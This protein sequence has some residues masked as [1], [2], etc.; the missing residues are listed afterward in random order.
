M[1]KRQQIMKTN[2][3]KRFAH[4]VVTFGLADWQS[5]IVASYKIGDTHINSEASGILRTSLRRS[6]LRVIKKV[7]GVDPREY[8]QSDY[9]PVND[10]HRRMSQIIADK[11][12]ERLATSTR[13]INT[14]ASKWVERATTLAIS[15]QM[16]QASANGVLRNYLNNHRLIIGLTEGNWAVEASRSASVVSLNDPLENTVSEISR[17]VNIGDY[18]GAN[19]LAR[20]ASKLATMPNSVTQGKLIRGLKGYE[21][22][23]AN[24]IAQGEA[25]ANLERRAG[26]LDAERKGWEAIGDDKTRETHL[27]AMITY[28]ED[29]AIPVNQPFEVGGY[30]LQYPGDGSLGAALDEIINCR[31]ATVYY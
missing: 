22:V 10:A 31:C 28:S 5:E 4:R 20:R 26:E 27:Q 25:I 30:L 2:R 9:D 8:K 19:R 23:P 3:D 21:R 15:E 13:S 11:T 29:G 16:T 24:P 18:N 17:L 1:T 7:T 12:G 14:T 6:Y